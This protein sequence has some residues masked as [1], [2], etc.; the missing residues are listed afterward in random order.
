MDLTQT[1]GHRT[2]HLSI[3]L[4]EVADELLAVSFL[5]I[6]RH[7][8][9]NHSHHL[10]YGHQA[11]GTYREDAQQRVVSHTLDLQGALRQASTLFSIGK[12]SA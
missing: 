5:S 9:L 11:T 1:T 12:S 2:I 7:T 6:L 8:D 3:V 10:L 4:I